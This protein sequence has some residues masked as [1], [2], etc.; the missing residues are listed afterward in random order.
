MRLQVLKTYKLYIGG[1]FPRTESEHYTAITSP[2]GGRLLANVC[3]GSRK[4]VR[5]AIEAARKAHEGWNKQTALNRGQVLYRVAEMLEARAG[6]LARQL[7]DMGA[8][9][10]AARAEVEGA[11]DTVVHYAG[12]S[13]KF[14][15]VL[16]STN[17]V[18]GPFYNFSVPEAV[19]VVGVIAPDEPALLGLV[20]AVVPAM[21]SG[22]TCVVI[23][24]EARPLSAI[25]FA[26]ALATGDVPGGVVNIVTGPV[27]ELAPVLASHED[28]DALD[29]RGVS[30]AKRGPLEERAAASTKRVIGRL[31]DDAPG[32][33]SPW[34]IAQYLETKTVWHPMGL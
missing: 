21:V 9:L 18:A 2:D 33:R 11:I 24:S 8:P 15:A 1:Q 26:E 31:G 19:G 23:P 20:E 12:W 3:K 16:G 5:N 34:A 27:A 28:V 14:Q 32:A 7:R 30:A 6:E 17:P 13:D 29:L 10:A 4:D 25:T 22:N